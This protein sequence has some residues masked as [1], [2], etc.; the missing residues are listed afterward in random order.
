M[1]DTAVDGFLLTLNLDPLLFVKKKYW[2]NLKML[3]STTM[4]QDLMI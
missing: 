1:Y 2:T 3:Y 4:I